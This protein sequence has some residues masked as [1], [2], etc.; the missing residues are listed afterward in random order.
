MVMAGSGVDVVRHFVAPVE[1]SDLLQQLLL[2]VFGAAAVYGVRV[3]VESI[4][5]DLSE[6]PVAHD[7]TAKDVVQRVQQTGPLI[8]ALD[9]AP[10]LTD[11][12]MG[13]RMLLFLASVVEIRGLL[14]QLSF[15]LESQLCVLHGLE[16]LFSRQPLEVLLV[17]IAPFWNGDFLL[18]R[19]R[20]GSIVSAKSAADLEIRP[21]PEIRA[22]QA[23]EIFPRAEAAAE[24]SGQGD[25]ACSAKPASPQLKI[26]G[27]HGN[28]TTDH[29]RH[30]T[31]C[32]T[33]C[34]HLHGCWDP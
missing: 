23:L 8:S 25:L 16:P 33:G 29:R 12:K 9:L 17:D 21:R 30:S 5:R 28:L 4:V 11:V 27:R 7:L 24:D 32:G 10:S 22:V 20:S 1:Q 2:V 6:L 3:V 14:Q 15:R 18:D 19:L 31:I 26:E 34:L 13:I